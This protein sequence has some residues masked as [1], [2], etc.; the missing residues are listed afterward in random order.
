MISK[1]PIFRIEAG[2]GE[3][4]EVGTTPMAAAA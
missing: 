2:L 4:V 1:E 3:I